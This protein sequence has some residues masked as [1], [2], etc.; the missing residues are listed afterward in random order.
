MAARTSDRHPRCALWRPTPMLARN[1][2]TVRA[3]ASD[4]RTQGRGRH[5]AGPGSGGPGAGAPVT[6]RRPVD[7]FDAAVTLDGRVRRSASLTWAGHAMTNMGE[8][9]LPVIF[10]PKAAEG[11]LPPPRRSVENIHGMFGTQG[12][13]A[14]PRSVPVVRLP[15]GHDGAVHRPGGQGPDRSRRRRQGASAFAHAGL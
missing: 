1:T 11:R 14:L 8:S 12:G 6:E 10:P 15:S 5:G 13:R 9:D 4:H 2:T 3:G 7:L